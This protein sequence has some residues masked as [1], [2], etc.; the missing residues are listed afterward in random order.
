MH[1]QIGHGLGVLQLIRLDPHVPDARTLGG[2]EHL[3]LQGCLIG[4]LRHDAAQGIDLTNH[5]PF[6]RSAD[7]RIAGHLGDMV[8]LDGDQNRVLARMG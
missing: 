1:A 7:R 8:Q 6:G 4:D 2:I 3:E 5:D